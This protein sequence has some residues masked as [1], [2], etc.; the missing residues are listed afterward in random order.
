VWE[1][2]D[3]PAGIVMV[4]FEPPPP[5]IGVGESVLESTVPDTGSSSRKVTVWPPTKLATLPFRV[6]GSEVTVVEELNDS[7][8]PD[9]TAAALSGLSGPVQGPHFAATLYLQVPPG[10]LLSVQLRAE[11]VPEQELPIVCSAP[12]EL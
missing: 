12:P 3:V 8:G 10:T 4:T 11:T 6:V 7:D 1:P 9:T 2:F 5:G